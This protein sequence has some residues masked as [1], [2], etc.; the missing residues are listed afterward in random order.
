MK[1]IRI[2]WVLIFGFLLVNSCKKQDSNDKN[3]NQSSNSQFESSNKK[4]QDT[5]DVDKYN[6]LFFHPTEE[7]FEILIEQYG[8][9]L[10]EVDSDFAFYANIVYDSVSKTDLRVKFVAERFIKLTTAYGIKYIDR[11]TNDEGLYGVIFNRPNC[12]PQIEYGV[13]TDLD[14][15]QVLDNYIKNCD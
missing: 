12:D 7:E 3:I 9:S 14:L 6:V 10:N 5:V 15:F 2:G 4:L 11:T 13:M 1:N 8:E